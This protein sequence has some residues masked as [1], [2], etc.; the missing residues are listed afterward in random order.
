MLSQGQSALVLSSRSESPIEA[1]CNLLITKP[2]ETRAQHKTTTGNMETEF[3][4]LDEALGVLDDLIPQFAPDNQKFVDD[5]HNARTI[6]DTSAS[7]ASPVKPTPATAA[8]A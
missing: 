7:H 1:A 5:Y 4:L 8:K 6:V 2:R 3:K